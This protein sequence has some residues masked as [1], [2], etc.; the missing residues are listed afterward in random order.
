MNLFIWKSCFLTAFVIQFFCINLLNCFSADTVI[1]AG[2]YQNEPKIYINDQD[3]PA[4][5]FTELLNEIA[6]NEGWQLEYV[7]G[8]WDK[9]I[10]QLRAGEIDIMPD[11]AYSV[12]R[13]GDFDFNRIPVIHSWSHLYV[14]P[15]SKI[16][17]FSDL[18]GKR[19]AMLSGAVQVPVLR[20][21]TEGFGY[22]CKIITVRSY[23]EAF[24]L[25]KL[26]LAD[27]VAVNYL[28]GD[29]HYKQY[30]LEKSPIVFNPV[31]LHFAVKLNTNAG[32]LATIDSYLEI[33][34][35]TPDSFYFRT[36]K[37][38]TGES[39]VPKRRVHI[40]LI[41]IMTGSVVILTG[42]LFIVSR[43]VVTN[44]TRNSAGS[45]E[46]LLKEKKELY[47]YLDY[48]PYGMFRTNE[49]GVIIE[50][51]PGL[52]RITGYTGRELAGK[53][54]LSLIPNPEKKNAGMQFKQPDNGKMTEG[55][56]PVFAKSGDQRYCKIDT[57][58]LPGNY[59]LGFVSD[60]T[61]QMADQKRVE[62][63]SHIIEYS[64]NEVY[65]FEPRTFRIVDVNRAALNNTGY[66]IEEIRKLT[67]P[68]L[69]P[70]FPREEF[71][72]L[73]EPLEKD[74]S[75]KIVFETVHA[76]KDGSLYP[77]EIQLQKICCEGEEL[78]VAVAIDITERKKK[79]SELRKLKEE[80]EMKVAGKTKELKERLAE[81]EYFQEV[82]LE[83]EARIHELKNEIA[84]L[85]NKAREK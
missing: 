44:K 82:T 29:L 20:Q 15:R 3:R 6:K 22:D 4:G 62:R 5:L 49:D 48:A 47:S 1:R 63:L 45:R 43:K 73:V 36:L 67:V 7:P 60:I 46:A 75:R 61:G 85:K 24:Q 21:K 80:L 10:R 41:W 76:R 34:G 78:F 14:R 16:R 83:R 55:I 66:S 11:M 25:V 23:L 54:I 39:I 37:K 18:D 56:Y 31:P 13:S 38:Y 26:N 72:R 27:A 2:I 79:E 64:L 51:N 65:L 81:L 58:K 32:L 52:C 57:V 53:E 69:K 74:L 70:E 35:N 30:K 40:D 28:Y 9:C 8:T 19:V 84:K 42:I 50:N 68:D 71:E 77:L 59:M 12:Q 33:W 17:Q